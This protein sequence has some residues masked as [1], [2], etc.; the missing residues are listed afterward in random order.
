MPTPFSLSGQQVASLSQSFCVT[1]VELT[2][3][4]GGEGG[5]GS[6]AELYDCKKAWPSI[7]RSMFSGPRCEYT[8]NDYGVNDT[9]SPH[10]EIS[11]Q[12]WEAWIF[13]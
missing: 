7:N 1:P 3:G 10:G 11:W 9:R 2:D 13:M 5:G 4:R 8:A 12:S 6:G